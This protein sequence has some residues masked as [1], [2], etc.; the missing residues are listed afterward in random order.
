MSINMEEEKAK[1]LRAFREDMAGVGVEL[2]PRDLALYACGVEISAVSSLP[3][4]SRT[5][6]MMVIFSELVTTLKR[7]GE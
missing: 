1:A 5:P 2:S 4:A 7:E 6:A 3:L